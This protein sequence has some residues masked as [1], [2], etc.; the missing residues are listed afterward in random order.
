MI[1]LTSRRVCVQILDR[2]QQ[3]LLFMAIDA[4]EFT[5][6]DHPASEDPMHGITI[7][8]ENRTDIWI[9]VRPKQLDLVLY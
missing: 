4:N 8:R 5:T 3:R 7:L 2:A 9:N 6:D 1:K